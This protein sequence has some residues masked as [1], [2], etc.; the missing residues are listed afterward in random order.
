MPRIV[1]TTVYELGELSGAARQ[2]ARAWYRECCLD[3]DWHEYV[4]VDNRGTWFDGPALL[5]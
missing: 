2:R 4:Y 1:E 5:R 3:W